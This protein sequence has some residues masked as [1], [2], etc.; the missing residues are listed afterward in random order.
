MS[1]T[2][3]F[4]SVHIHEYAGISVAADQAKK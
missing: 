4:I 3:L 1:I 2:V